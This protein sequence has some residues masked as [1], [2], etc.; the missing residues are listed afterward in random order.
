[1]LREPSDPAASV[2]LPLPV[3]TGSDKSESQ[4]VA[5]AE[6]SVRLDEA[7]RYAAAND[8]QKPS[9]RPYRKR[10]KG[11]GPR[12]KSSRI[13]ELAQAPKME[14]EPSLPITARA[15]SEETEQPEVPDMAL[16]G[17]VSRGDT[18][19]F[20]EPDVAE[21]QPV[22]TGFPLEAFPPAKAQK[23]GRGRKGGSSAVSRPETPD[24]E[25]EQRQKRYRSQ[26]AAEPAVS[27]SAL[28]IKFKPLSPPDSKKRRKK[29]LAAET[30]KQRGRKAAHTPGL[31]GRLLLRAS[32]RIK[33]ILPKKHTATNLAPTSNGTITAPASES[34]QTG[35]NDDY[36]TTCGGSG[37]FICC[38]SCSKS[39]HFLCCDPPI[40][41]CPDDNWNCLECTAKKAPPPAYN[42]L[43]LFGQLVNHIAN[44][45]PAEFQLPKR[46]REAF[47]GVSTEEDG[48]YTDD[49]F[50]PDLSY[51]KRNG[52]QLP[53]CNR[54]ESLEV[55]SLY[56]DGK[57]LL[58]HRCKESGLPKGRGW[59]TMASCDYCDAYWHLDCLNEPMCVPKTMGS[60]WMCPN[61]ASQALP[62]Y[63]LS[64]RFKDASVVDASLH[65]S[66][67]KVATYNS[68][69]IKTR[70][71]PY[72]NDNANG[73]VA[74]QEYLQS[75]EGD[76][77][78]QDNPNT[79]D[80]DCHPDFKVPEHLHTFAGPGGIYARS[81]KRLK[82]VLT[83]TNEENDGKMGAFVYR[84]PE[85]LV[86]LDFFV[87]VNKSKEG[88][89]ADVN[90]YE[91]RRR[92]ETNEREREGVNGL[93]G[94]KESEDA[95][96][97]QK[98][99][100]N[101][102][103]LVTIAAA[104]LGTSDKVPE[105][106]KTPASELTAE[107]LEE[108]VHIKRLMQIKGKQKLVDFLTR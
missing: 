86:L 8:E 60:R 88:I 29:P 97:Q 33:V 13:S 75:E 51:T 74:L 37:V 24:S 57:P 107:E 58:C 108:L 71:Q 77:D 69:H 32:K 30:P 44:K 42:Y 105:G 7:P 23:S 20:V 2:R 92:L 54:D 27:P 12:R 98:S 35:E 49:R 72:I 80:G 10:E 36:C 43:G 104:R 41:E 1:M 50:K 15:A 9:K 28:R 31:D 64:R 34:E 101:F 102:E 76:A 96:P 47:V 85:E 48:T 53:G 94:M 62:S 89:L 39:F 25:L 19:V 14:L 6:D 17:V 22:Y 63:I 93:V 52:S 82:K 79:H 55:D 81:G 56:K 83:L 95:A 90:S 40:E 21:P 87:K 38:D 59:R 70:D 61:H 73:L 65:N 4:G 18:R 11:Q 99:P 66:F 5:A 46:L 91:D 67:V 45:D 26:L 68:F 78:G 84:V 106:K 100:I 16:S 103:Q 3:S